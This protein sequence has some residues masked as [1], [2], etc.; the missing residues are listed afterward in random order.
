MR[1]IWC[2]HYSRCLEKTASHDKGKGKAKD[3]NCSECE[4]QG[5]TDAMPKSRADMIEDAIRCAALLLAVYPSLNPD[6][7]L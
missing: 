5:N 7:Y 3:L 4:H 1:N 6:Q 2:R